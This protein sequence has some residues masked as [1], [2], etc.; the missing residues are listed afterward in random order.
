MRSTT[1][2]RVGAVSRADFGDLGHRMSG[3]VAEERQHAPLLERRALRLQRLT[4]PLD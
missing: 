1:L 2:V 4:D 3:A